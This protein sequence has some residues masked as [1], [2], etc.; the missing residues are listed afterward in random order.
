MA[1][2]D[3]HTQVEVAPTK[4][5]WIPQPPMQCPRA[6]VAQ[7]LQASVEGVELAWVSV[8]P[9]Q[10]APRCLPLAH[11]TSEADALAADCLPLPL[12]LA[13]VAP[14]LGL[15]KQLGLEVRLELEV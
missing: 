13:P 10:C 6:L 12:R 4:V 3:Q 2:G 5:L 7:V 1:S 14:R 9:L 15:E 8:R 11:P